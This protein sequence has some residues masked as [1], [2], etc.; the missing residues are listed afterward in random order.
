MREWLKNA[1][2]K[3]G[4]S[5]RETARRLE[6]GQQYYS[7]IENGTRQKELQLLMAVRLSE[8]LQ[9]PLREIIEAEGGG[10]YRPCERETG[11]V[12]KHV[13]EDSNGICDQDAVSVPNMS[14]T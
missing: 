8:L 1:R 2:D 4:L 6:I 12:R 11:T 5:Q 10:R 14:L 3:K 13:Q 9:I 7:G